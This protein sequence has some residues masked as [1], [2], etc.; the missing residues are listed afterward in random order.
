MGGLVEGFAT[1]GALIGVGAI[2][3]HAGLF[4]V[5]TQQ[6]LAKLAFF[7]AT[8]AL[9]I[10]VLQDTEL[11][12]VFSTA[13]L[14]AV[15][16]VAVAAGLYVVV[17]V[18]LFRHSLAETTIGALCASYVNA[19]NLGLPIAAYVLGDA[20]LAIPM[21]L[22]QLLFLQPLA[23][24]ILDVAA[25]E[26]RLVWWNVALRPLRTP[27]TVAATT[28]AGLSLTDTE[29]PPLI[30][31]PLSH[32]AAMAI[33]GILIAYGIS[34]RLGPRPG[35]ETGSAALVTITVIKL[36]VQPL[37]ALLV[38]LAV[39]APD[40][41]VLTVTVM[42]ALPTAQNIFVFA[43]RYSRGTHLARDAIFITTVL[44]VPAIAVISVA[45]G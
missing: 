40:H 18:L 43:A 30:F 19:G 17:S 15:V 35:A 34:L 36:I 20:A 12:G 44:S 29:I 39:G 38:A 28:G 10:V 23:L 33:P 42:A 32:V 11:S 9:L 22:L 37:V 3:A 41:V 31:E 4:D 16:S 7:V 2:L 13:L 24:T 5:V 14:S 27:L 8:P 6:V 45:L 25:A 1:V 26:R 21:M